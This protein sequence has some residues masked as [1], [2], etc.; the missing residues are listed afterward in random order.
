MIAF[1]SAHDLSYV[2]LVPA[3]TGARK[4]DPSQPLFNDISH[5]TLNGHTIALAMLLRK[6]QALLPT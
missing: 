5:S 6:V 1:A 4:L 2:D 3:F